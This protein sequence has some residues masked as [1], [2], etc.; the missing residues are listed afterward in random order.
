LQSLLLAIVAESFLPKQQQ[1][2]LKAFSKM[3]ITSLVTFFSFSLAAAAPLKTLAA[4]G[5]L[6][7]DRRGLERRNHFASTCKSW[8]LNTY[9]Y[10][11]LNAQCWNTQGQ[12]VW[13]ALD[14]N[15]CIANYG[16]HLAYAK[17]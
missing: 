2:E 13:N 10:T 17:K 3:K 7:Q 14:L 11:I 6:V 12:P 9:Y 4:E 1:V 16:G 15:G 8:D 5:Q